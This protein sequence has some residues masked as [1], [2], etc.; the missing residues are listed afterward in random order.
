MTDQPND[1]AAYVTSTA[2]TIHVDEDA[3]CWADITLRDAEH[4]TVRCGRAADHDGPHVGNV[5][6][7]EFVE[8]TDADHA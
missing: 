8:W 6:Q 4:A 1:K 2:D 3:R 7:D 5:W